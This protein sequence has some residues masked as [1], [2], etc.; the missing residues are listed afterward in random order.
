MLENEILTAPTISL[1]RI[2]VNLVVENYFEMR[3]KIC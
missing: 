2:V 1:D 3:E